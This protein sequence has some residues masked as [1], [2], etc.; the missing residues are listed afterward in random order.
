MTQFYDLTANE[1]HASFIPIARAD[2]TAFFMFQ[3]KSQNSIQPEL[4]VDPVE[5][6]RQGKSSKL[7]YFCS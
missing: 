6:T 3:A 5:S 7:P 2:R 4:V 1:A